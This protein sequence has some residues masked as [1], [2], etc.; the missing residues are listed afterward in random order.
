M[1]FFRRSLVGLMLTALTI[2]LL[3]VAGQIV[4]SAIATRM[5]GG[6]PPP[7]ARER[8]FTANVV[9]AKAAAVAPI[10]SAFGEIRSS[11]T[12]EL[13]SPR[14]GTVK[15]LAPTFQDGGHVTA[16]DLLMTLDPADATAVRDIAQADMG[17][18]EAEARDA[19]RGLLLARDDLAAAEAQAALREQALQRQRDLKTRRVGSD[20]GVETAALAASVADQS[21]LSRRAALDAAAARV[22]QAATAIA[23]QSITLAEAERALRETRLYA[24]FD[25]TLSAVS[26]VAGRILSANER[27]GDLIDPAALEVSF[28]LSTAQYTRLIDADGALLPTGLTV[29]LEVAGAQIAARGTLD[30]VSASVE[31]GQTGRLVYA[32]LDRAAGFRPGDFVTVRVEEPE[33]QNVVTL[34]GTA[35]GSD[36]TLLAV[37]PEE[38]LEAIP[39]TLLRRQSDSVIVAAEGVA[40][41]DV[42]AVRTPLLGTGIRIKP[43]RPEPRS[44]ADGAEETA[45]MVDLTPE[46]RASLVAYVEGNAGMPPDAKARILAQLAEPQVPEQ[47]V[48]RLEQRMGG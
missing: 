24:A 48:T 18:A 6:K 31:A 26:V 47:V 17:R 46:R 16:G 29:S 27:I 5:A 22:D 25:G 3:A 10:L 8:I 4:A 37:G 45:R 38:R 20:A 36:N 23:R 34:P 40:G 9:T 11:R 43:V 42:V 13:R 14:A 15:A 21:V 32:T 30:R 2:G 1:R 39:T 28:R 33:M 41:R 35:L 19:D 7:P 44:P 12:L